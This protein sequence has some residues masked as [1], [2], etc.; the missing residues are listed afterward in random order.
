MNSSEPPLLLPDRIPTHV[1]VVMDGNGRW[2]EQRGLSRSEGHWTALA[3]MFETVEAALTVG[4]KWLSVFAF[5]SENWQRST[6]E[7][8]G[9]LGCVT[10]MAG[11]NADEIV[12]RGIRFRWCGSPEGLPGTLIDDLHELEKATAS[13]TAINCTLCFNYGGRADIVQA[14]RKAVEA[15]RAG[16]LDP[17]DLNEAALARL[18]LA[19]DLPDVDLLIRSGGEQ[20]LSNFMLWQCA[21]AEIAFLPDLWPDVTRE[22]LWQAIADYARRERRFGGAPTTATPR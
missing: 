5:S 22:H 15:A 7:V 11:E 1:A 20:R 4:V 21:Y 18:M 16:R 19:P 9:L 14:A 2:A 12:K 6:D 8:E 13:G 10:G 17:E 3:R